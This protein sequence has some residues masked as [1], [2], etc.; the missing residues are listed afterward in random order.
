MNTK[1]RV[2]GLQVVTLAMVAGAVYVQHP[3][4]AVMLILCGT[5]IAVLSAMVD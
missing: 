3:A 1:L 5:V 2:I 4:K